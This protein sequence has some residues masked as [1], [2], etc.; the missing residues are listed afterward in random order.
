LSAGSPFWAA[1]LLLALLA[2]GVIVRPLYEVLVEVCGGRDRARFWTVYSCALTLMAPLLTV[3]TPGLLDAAAASGTTG[4]V[5]QR[6]VFYALVGVIGALLIIGR[7]VWRPIA[8]M[9]EDPVT[10]VPRGTREK[11]S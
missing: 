1:A 6:A 7:A 5:H 3:S 4:A 8:R 11:A 9:L 10:N 2:I